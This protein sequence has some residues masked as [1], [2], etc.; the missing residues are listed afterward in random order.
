MR[1]GKCVCFQGRKRNVIQINKML[2][3]VGSNLPQ[4]RLTKIAAIK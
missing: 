4:E 1:N 2:P 3:L